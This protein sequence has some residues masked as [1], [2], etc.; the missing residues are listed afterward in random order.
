MS[1]SRQIPF[2]F[3][4]SL[5]I[6]LSPSPNA[7]AENRPAFPAITNPK[8]GGTVPP[9]DLR[10]AVTSNRPDLQ[11]V[12]ELLD[13]EDFTIVDG[14]KTVEFKGNT[15]SV[16]VKIPAAEENETEPKIF[17]LQVSAPSSKTGNV[18]RILFDRRVKGMAPNEGKPPM[19]I[20][21]DFL[22]EKQRHGGGW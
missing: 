20:T 16:V 4:L 5:V 2:Y 17:M 9:G 6:F 8:S 11:H 3:L 12:V 13:A 19:D 7:F 10:V 22:I 21:P 14:P 1:S 15:G 18:H